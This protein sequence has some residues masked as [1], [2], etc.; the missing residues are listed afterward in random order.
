M[1]RLVLIFTLFIPLITFAQRPGKLPYQTVRQTYREDTVETTLGTTNVEY[2]TSKDGY[3]FDKE[4]IVRDSTILELIQ[5]HGGGGGSYTFQNGLTES[6]NNVEL[7]GLDVLGNT[8][9]GRENMF[10]N[11]E[12]SDESDT[13]IYIHG[14]RSDKQRVA[15]LGVNKPILGSPNIWIKTT[16]AGSVLDSL[17]FVYDGDY[18]SRNT[19][20]PRWIPDKDYV[21]SVVEASYAELYFSIYAGFSIDISNPAQFGWTKWQRIS[22]ATNSVYHVGFDYNATDSINYFTCLNSGTYKIT[23]VVNMSM[24]Y[25]NTPPHPRVG[26]FVN[27]YLI[28]TSVSINNTNSLNPVILS[29]CF[30]A[31]INEGETVKLKFNPGGELDGNLSLHTI[32]LVITKL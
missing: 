16:R 23:Y 14:F 2:T 32:N 5:E 22:P 28:P 24:T 20:N 17:G 9:I 29:N 4:V 13:G 12:Y 30:I 8:K 15:I 18:A 10:F 19:S 31:A 7:G 25:A 27:D 26:V 21:D 6:T 11:F 1:K 3:S